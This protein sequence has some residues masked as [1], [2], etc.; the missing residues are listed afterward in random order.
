[1]SSLVGSRPTRR[2]RAV[3]SRLVV[4]CAV[5]AVAGCTSAAGDGN[6]PTPDRLGMLVVPPGARQLAPRISGTTLTGAPF[7]LASSIRNHVTLVNVWASWCE[8]C[9][10][11]MPMLVRAAARLP[12]L[13][14]VGI[15]ER[16]RAASAREILAAIGA[17][18]PSLVDPDSHILVHLPMLPHDAVPSSLFIDPEGRVAGRVIGPLTAQQLT[19]VLARIR[20]TS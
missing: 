2:P 20:A 7:R 12:Q 15:D 10:Q 11:E 5:I 18:Y 14:V 6:S 4:A 19:S 3:L 8:P 13:R 1:M 16:D 17:R 9:K